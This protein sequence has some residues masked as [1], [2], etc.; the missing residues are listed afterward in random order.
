MDM[1]E[2]AMDMDGEAMDMDGAAIGMDGDR[3][4][5]PFAKTTHV[6]IPAETYNAEPTAHL[7][8]WSREHRSR[9]CETR[10]PPDLHGD[11][12]HQ[13]VHLPVKVRRRGVDGCARAVFPRVATPLVAI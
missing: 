6:F 7:K 5:N 9:D 1:D 3:L 12:Q 8:I 4:L 2:E 13:V 11:M 10:L